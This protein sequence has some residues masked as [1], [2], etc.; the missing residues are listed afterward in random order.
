MLGTATLDRP[1]AADGENLELDERVEDE[2]ASDTAGAV[3]REAETVKLREAVDR[4]PSGC[5]TSL[6]GATPSTA[7]SRPTS[8]K[9]GSA[10]W[11]R[12]RGAP[13]W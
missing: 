4:L 11:R 10:V 6:S 3:I 5:G 1:V 9:A 13:G 7:L 12:R 2:G 8:R